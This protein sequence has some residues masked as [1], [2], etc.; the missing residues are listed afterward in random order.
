[1]AVEALCLGFG[2]KVPDS[3]VQKAKCPDA[4]SGS[5]TNRSSGVVPE[6]KRRTHIIAT[7]STTEHNL[8]PSRCPRAGCGTEHLRD[9]RYP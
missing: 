6:R 7:N 9:R 3:N 8:C 2:G 1:M 4:G 5:K